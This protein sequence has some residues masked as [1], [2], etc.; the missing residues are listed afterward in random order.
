MS[1]LQSPAPDATQG[2]RY[3]NFIF[4][5]YHASQQQAPFSLVPRRVLEA[6]DIPDEVALLLE[7]NK[8]W[9]KS[10]RMGVHGLQFAGEP[11]YFFSLMWKAQAGVTKKTLETEFIP[12]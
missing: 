6:M 7:N 1:Q 12:R 2:R 8:R 9:T 10:L 5:C 11:R 3:A 4:F